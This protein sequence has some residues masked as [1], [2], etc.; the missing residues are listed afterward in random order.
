MPIYEYECALCGGAFEW[1]QRM[2]DPY[3]SCVICN[4]GEVERLISAPGIIEDFDP[5]I[6][7]DIDNKPVYVRT[8]QDLRDSVA[9]HND[10]EEADKMGKLAVYDGIRTNKVNYVHK[11]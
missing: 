8:K 7:T 1:I 2:N 4:C 5:Y 6:E 9:R 10:G 3:P 11:G